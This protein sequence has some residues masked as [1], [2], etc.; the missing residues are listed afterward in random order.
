MKKELKILRKD[1]LIPKK[2]FK[3]INID[4]NK[5]IW[6]KVVFLVKTQV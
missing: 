3:N 4:F 2:E 5:R 6:K 1:L